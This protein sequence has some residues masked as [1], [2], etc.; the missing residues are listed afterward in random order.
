MK[1][2]ARRVVPRKTGDGCQT[3]RV[4]ISEKTPAPEARKVVPTHFIKE[5]TE[6]LGVQTVWVIL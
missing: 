1:V 6:I 2:D 5:E 4:S 3:R